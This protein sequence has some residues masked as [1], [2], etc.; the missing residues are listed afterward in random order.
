MPKEVRRTKVPLDQGLPTFQ[1]AVAA[2]CTSD[3]VRELSK[4]SRTQV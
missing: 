1:E 3:E 2:R 4:R